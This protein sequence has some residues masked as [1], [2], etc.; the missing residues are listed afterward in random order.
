MTF[1]GGALLYSGGVVARTEDGRRVIRRGDFV[2]REDDDLFVPALW[3]PR[4]ITAY[5]QNG[6][7]GKTWRL[8]EDWP[9]VAGVEVRRVTMEGFVLRQKAVRIT[10]GKVSLSLDAGEAISIVP[11]E[12]PIPGG[13]TVHPDE[14][15]RTE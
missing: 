9:G 8:P 15:V 6:Y 3:N 12:A 7:A 2:L 11:T 10:A 13:D 4:E 14:R 5:S 1:A